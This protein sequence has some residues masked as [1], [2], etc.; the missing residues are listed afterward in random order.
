MHGKGWLTE[1]GESEK[2]WRLE[3]DA[4]MRA[5]DERS[6]ARMA[7]MRRD[8]ATEEA[9][10]GR[11]LARARLLPR[12]QEAGT[13]RVRD[14]QSG[15]VDVVDDT[16]QQAAKVSTADR[17]GSMMLSAVE[18]DLFAKQ[19][20][21]AA[22]KTRHLSLIS[23]AAKVERQEEALRVA[24]PNTLLSLEAEFQSINSHEA[25]LQSQLAAVEAASATARRDLKQLQSFHGNIT[26]TRA[27]KLRDRERK[28]DA[29]LAS[30][31]HLQLELNA[32]MRNLTEQ[33][34][35][36]TL[37]L[38][39]AL[40]ASLQERDQM[41]ASLQRIRA[42]T[43]GCQH[44]HAQAQL[45]LSNITQALLGVD[46]ASGDA[47]AATEGGFLSCIAREVNATAET[48]RAYERELAGA[49]ERNSKLQE[50]LDLL[51]LQ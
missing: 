43:T 30:V 47:G 39:R 18:A 16:R 6:S 40:N 22:E 9:E 23:E 34:E 12:E 45:L 31:N 41:A 14:E 10:L 28:R 19:A 37:D 2:K 48:V 5:A 15:V 35:R 29:V 13:E 1:T 4:Q 25:R 49:F 11:A 3:V 7:Q 51:R 8:A 20:R 27:A 50:M 42:E 44:R 26:S 46:A 24:H 33:G 36:R 32:T 21:L 38:S 17:P